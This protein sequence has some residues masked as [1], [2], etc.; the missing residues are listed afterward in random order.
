MLDPRMSG[1]GSHWWPTR[2]REA[3]GERFRQVLRRW[4]ARRTAAELESL[5]DAVL[6]DIGI[7]RA[8]IPAVALRVTAPPRRPSGARTGAIT[9]AF[10][11]EVTT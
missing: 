1:F 6:R 7:T 2:L 10:R 11:K 4:R 9:D 3:L 8:E 5:D